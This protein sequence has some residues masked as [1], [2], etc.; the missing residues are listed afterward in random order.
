M[1]GPRALSPTEHAVLGL[2]AE[3]STHGFAISKELG[4]GS[5]VGRLLTVRRPLVYRALARLVELGMA[6]PL[7]TEPGEAG[8]Q[9]VIH[10]VTRHGRRELGIWLA[11][12][13]GHIREL[14]IEFQLKLALIL[15]SGR[16]PLELVR[17]QRKALQPQI[18]ALGS[19][20]HMD[21]LDLWRHH[22]A[23]AA[24]AYLDHL[25]VL[26]STGGAAFD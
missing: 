23:R 14:R 7:H 3:G 17:A 13:V 22:N 6:K 11:Q 24:A 18:E 12:P 16:S 1:M 15:R 20:D 4:A 5:Q 21:H 8:P 26:Y 25:D 2:L 9:R 10:R 19:P